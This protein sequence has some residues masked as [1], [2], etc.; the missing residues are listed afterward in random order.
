MFETTS[1]EISYDAEFRFEKKEKFDFA[2]KKE[3]M[4]LR[5]ED[6]V[7][8]TIKELLY[9]MVKDTE[10][11]RPL[12]NMSSEDRARC[13]LA[14][15]VICEEACRLSEAVANKVAILMG[16]VAC[17]NIWPETKGRIEKEE[18]LEAIRIYIGEASAHRGTEE[19]VDMI[20]ALN[21]LKDI[22]HLGK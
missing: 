15:N 17:M 3:E 22:Q 7:Y 8:G 9:A 19:T 13:G 6:A 2:A 16:A 18:A 21:S 4:E 20:R 12:V 5:V 11:C 14:I 10:F 1:N